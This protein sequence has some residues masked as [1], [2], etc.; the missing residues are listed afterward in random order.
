MTADQWHRMISNVDLLVLKHRIIYDG[1]KKRL[2]KHTLLLLIFCAYFA[3]GKH[4]EVKI[5]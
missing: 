3:S 2:Q 1:G 4:K 5:S